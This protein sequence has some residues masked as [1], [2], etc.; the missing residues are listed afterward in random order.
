MSVRPSFGRAARRILLRL[1]LCPLALSLGSAAGDGLPSAHTAGSQRGSRAA[2]LESFEHIWKTVRD[3]HWDPGL[4]G[5]D[6][7]A[8][9]REF[10]PRLE[11]ST[12]TE[13]ARSIMNEMIAR[14]GQ[15]H[16]AVVPS[17]VY[18]EMGNE[19][20]DD[21]NYPAGSGDPG[22]DVRVIDGHVVVTR[23]E[24]GSPAE[25]LGVRPGWEVR[26]VRGKPVRPVVQRVGEAYAGSTL[27]EA[28]LRRAVLAR[29]SGDIGERVR[30]VFLDAGDRSRVLETAL[31]RPRGNRTT[32]GHLA[33]QFVWFESR[34]IG[35]DI[36][37]LAFNLFFDPANVMKE[38]GEAVLAL[39][40][41][42]GIIIDLRGNP[43]GIGA[44]SMG[45]AGWFIAEPN[46]RLGTMYT[47]DTT[48]SFVVIPRAQT[49]S[50]P[51]A[52]LVD[53]CSVSTAEIFAGG[54]QDLG[55][56]RIFG[57]RTAGAALPSVFERLPNGDGFQYAVA[58]YISEGGLPLE[59]R[60]VVPDVEVPLARV[61]LLAGVDPVIDAAREW[62]QGRAKP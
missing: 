48:L 42:A 25:K 56:A 30:I 38:F 37:C 57:T 26:E 60:G 54:L 9:H 43:G 35:G 13:R 59:G 52:I 28:H 34:R 46:R 51:L 10:R 19:A 12:T 39:R 23:V 4:G 44:M 21:A 5:L 47:R 8:V 33:S 2:D 14:L 62:I 29:L 1:A 18:R 40:D 3:K 36:G 50:G 11:Q 17:S 41:S 58:N 15:S 20:P 22:I 49:Y 16:F 6:W 55:R 24:P 53:G 27:R 32:F 31:A 7:Q 61:A 45:M